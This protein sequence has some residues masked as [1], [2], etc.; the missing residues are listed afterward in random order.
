MQSKTKDRVLSVYM[1]EQPH[2]SVLSTICSDLQLPILVGMT[3]HARRR[4]GTVPLPKIKVLAI[5]A[6]QLA[7][8]SVN[9]GGLLLPAGRPDER[10]RDKERS[11]AATGTRPHS[12]H[13]THTHHLP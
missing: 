3:I 9:D 6:G 1:I 8:V 13:S 2:D 11:L 4:E 12:L 5:D 7:L 10:G